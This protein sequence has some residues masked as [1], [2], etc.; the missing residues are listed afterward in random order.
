[1]EVD[2]YHGAAFVA[3]VPFKMRAIRPAWLPGTWG[4]NFLETNVRTYV[5][6]R[7]QPGVFFYSLDANSRLAVWVA[8]LG[9]SLPYHY[10]RMQ[11][12]QQGPEIRYH[13]NRRGVRSEVA[14]RAEGDYRMA[15]ADT[16]EHFLL[17][18]YWLFVQRQGTLWAGQVHHA[19]YTF[20]PTQVLKLH[21]QL[22]VSAG[23]QV[24]ARPPDW[25][26]CSPGVD[27]EVFSIKPL[28]D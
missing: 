4:L 23:F 16:L 5:T 10:A 13:C 27:V 9:W 12:D 6:Y 7:G 17:E 11:G 25:A 20:A 21:D 8:R 3:L 19:P 26:H 22:T 24:A 1:L 28:T 18:R 15:T 14:Y 2:T